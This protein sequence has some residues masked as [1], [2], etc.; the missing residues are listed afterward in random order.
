[1]RED[2]SQWVA[3]PY[4]EAKILPGRT[5]RLEPLRATSHGDDLYQYA[6]QPS[7]ASRFAYL[8]EQPPQ[9][10]PEFDLFLS[11][12]EASHDPLYFAVID[13]ETGKAV[14]RQSFL[15][16]EPKHGVIEIGHIY[17]GPLMRGRRQATEAQ[18]LFADYVF[19]QLQYRR[20]EWKCHNDNVPSKQAALRFGFTFE[21]IFRQHMVAKGQNRDTAWFS[22]TN[23]DWDRLRPLYLEWLDEKN[24]TKDGQQKKRLS[25]LTRAPHAPRAL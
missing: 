14:G 2:L 24:F 10:R 9:T 23:R 15:R 18:F 8:P 16:I 4:P 20:Y 7:E 5:V 11:Q 12:A 19:R 21:G 25:D 13:Q 3:R 6:C 22:I 1:M 17:W